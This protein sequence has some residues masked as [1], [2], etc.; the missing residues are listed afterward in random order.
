[1]KHKAPRCYTQSWW[2]KT[3]GSEW[4]RKVFTFWQRSHLWKVMFPAPPEKYWIAY[5]QL[6][7]GKGA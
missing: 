6:E 4:E 3:A 5:A 7:T 1:M 2:Q